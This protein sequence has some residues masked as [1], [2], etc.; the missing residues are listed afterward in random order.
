MFAPLANLEAA[1]D[2]DKRHGYGHESPL[3]AQEARTKV[4]RCLVLGEAVDEC[5]H[6]GG[7]G[8]YGAPLLEGQVRRDHRGAVLVATGHPPPP[9]KV[10]PKDVATAP[11]S[12]G[13]VYS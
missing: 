5:D 4:V 1:L 3:L 6:A 8:E 13:K 9:I 12:V 7:A 10:E 11:L 2:H